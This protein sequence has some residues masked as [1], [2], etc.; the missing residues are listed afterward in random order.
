MQLSNQAKSVLENQGYRIVGTHSAVKTCGWTKNTL[1]GKGGC[2]KLKFYGIK[3]HKCMQMSTSISCANRCTFC[4]RDYK[5]PVSKT[6]DWNVDEPDMIFD[7][8][9]EAHHDL[10]VGFKGNPNTPKVLYEQSNKVEHVALSL[11]GEPITYPR[12]NELVRK[13]HSQKISTFLV[14]NAQ[15]PDA[16]RN[17]IP[18][19]QLYISLDAP[20][21]ELLKKV[22]VP[23]FKDYWERLNLSLEIM[24]KRLDRTCIRLTCIKDLN[25]I[26]PENYAKLIKK[27]SPDFI[28]VK[29]YMW[30]GASQERLKFENMP[31]SYEIEEFAMKVLEHLDDYEYVTEHSPSRVILLAKK[32]FNKQ[33][34]IDYPKF[35]EEYPSLLREWKRVK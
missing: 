23:L 17:L 15:Y 21:K 10:L 20:K 3:S 27:A 2:Y 6:W 24:A 30:V 19:T 35:F 18:V 31:K 32:K 26:E 7:K 4:W 5:S 29:G 33:T 11:T 25:M 28:E 1:R 34:W 12:M 16:I 13:F 14:T 9:L 22:D 8:S